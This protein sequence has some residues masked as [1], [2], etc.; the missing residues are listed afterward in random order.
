[1]D[2]PTPAPQKKEKKLNN[3]LGIEKDKQQRG[4]GALSALERG[5]RQISMRTSR[6][7]RQQQ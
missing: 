4:R 6:K 7:Q 3:N 5:E 2:R 1:L